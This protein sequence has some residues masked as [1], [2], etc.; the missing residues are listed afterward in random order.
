MLVW[1][2]SDAAIAHDDFRGLLSFADASAERI[3]LSLHCT[4]MSVEWHH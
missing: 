2:A 1:S 4:H 3:S